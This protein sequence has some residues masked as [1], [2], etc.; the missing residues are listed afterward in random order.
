MD[1][2]E[3]EIEAPLREVL[4]RTREV[5]PAGFSDRAIAAVRRDVARRRILLWSAP[6]AACAALLAAA[7]L[8]P[9][10]PR[11]VSEGELAQLVSLHEQ[12]V[13]ASPRL[14]DAEALAAILIDEYEAA[15]SVPRLEGAE[16]ALARIVL[17][18]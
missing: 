17:G 3:P 7:L 12:V 1:N 4:R 6:L 14:E 13:L 8:S 16:E 5:R 18:S 2:H 11:P 10:I 9:S 15:A